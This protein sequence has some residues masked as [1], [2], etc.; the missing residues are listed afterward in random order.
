MT[1]G[2]VRIIWE[3]YTYPCLDAEVS[4]HH[5]AHTRK[6]TCVCIPVD[7]ANIDRFDPSR[8]PTVSQLPRELNVAEEGAANTS[9]KLYVDM[10]DRH[11]ESDEECEERETSEL[12]Q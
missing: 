7:P 2:R 5:S 4:K 11:H 3:E 1:V 6:Q 12:P 8:V 10:L 9:L